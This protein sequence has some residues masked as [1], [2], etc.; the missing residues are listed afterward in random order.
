MSRHIREHADPFR[1]RSLR[2]PPVPA[3]AK[4]NEPD[5]A[6]RQVGTLVTGDLIRDGFAFI[7]PDNAGKDVFLGVREVRAS[8]LSNLRVGDRLRF[9]VGC[10]LSGKTHAEDIELVSKE[11]DHNV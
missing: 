11:K 8:G 10:R 3:P 4:P 1:P 7:R 2:E 6:E 5:P 9:S